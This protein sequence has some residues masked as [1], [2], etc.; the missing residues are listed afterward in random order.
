MQYLE[1]LN[2]LFFIAE[3]SGEELCVSPDGKIYAVKDRDKETA[4]LLPLTEPTAPV[5]SFN[6]EKLIFR[7]DLLLRSAKIEI[8]TA[9]NGTK[10]VQERSINGAETENITV[11]ERSINGAKTGQ[12]RIINGG[13]TVENRAVVGKGKVNLPRFSDLHGGDV[14]AVSVQ[15]EALIDKAVGGT[16]KNETIKKIISYYESAKTAAKKGNLFALKNIEKSLCG[17]VEKQKAMK[18]GVDKMQ[19]KAEVKKTLIKCLTCAALLS[20]IYFYFSYNSTKVAPTP[21]Q[22]AIFETDNIFEEAVMEFEQQT[23][24]KI[25]PAGRECLRRACQNCTT[26]QECFLIIK[27]NV[28]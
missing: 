13:G 16:N 4:S 27:A 12:Q 17:I 18:A 22:T 25:Y 2:A 20:V 28:K 26:K 10:T 21:L 6:P 9:Q 5:V 11:Q 8:L 15:I 1:I 19:H 3:K 24:K 14:A 23:N 7:T